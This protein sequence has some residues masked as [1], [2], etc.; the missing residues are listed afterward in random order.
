[1]KIVI[2]PD[3]FKESLTAQQVCLAVENGLK[4]VWPNA[5]Y[6]SIPVADGGEGT[7]QALI[8]ATSG[9]KI[10]VRVKDPRGKTVEARYGLLGDH[11]T[12]VIE[13]AEA[14]GLHLV[15]ASERDTKSTSSYGVGQLIRHALDSGISRLIIGLGGSATTDGGSGMLAALGVKF[16]NEDGEEIEPCG[17]SMLNVHQIATNEFDPRLAHCEIIVACDVDNPLCGDSGAAAFFGPQKGASSEDVLLLDKALYQFGQLTE[18]VMQRSIIDSK[19]SGAAG[20]IGAAFLG[21]TNATLQ[22]GIDVVLT[23]LDVE[24]KMQGAHM[25]ITGEGKLDQQTAHGKAPVGVAKIAKKFDIPV[26]AVAGCTNDGYQVLYE[27][28][29]DAVFTCVP[30][31]MSLS[32]AFS[33]AKTNLSNLAENIARTYQLALGK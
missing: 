20:G 23:M 28:G 21:Y 12:A 24:T 2:A 31:A 3:S 7:M 11:R 4:R 30:R 9:E 22:P 19:G 10:Q 6:V 16:L 5:E 26:V 25:V 32:D 8:D 15:P 18:K 1:V 29:I 14:C 33:E 27:H 13:V 17:A